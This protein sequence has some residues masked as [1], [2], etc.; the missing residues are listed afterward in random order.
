MDTSQQPMP[1]EQIIDLRRRVLAGEEVSNEELR[2]ALE[3]VTMR[4]VAPSET[5]PSRTSKT[6]TV[7]IDLAASFAAFKQKASGGSTP[8]S[9]GDNAGSSSPA[10]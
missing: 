3:S 10:S 1:N 8:V 5:S 7:K 4:R 2:R 6:P 9:G